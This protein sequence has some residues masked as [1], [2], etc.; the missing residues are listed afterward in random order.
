MSLR[1]SA[2][3]GVLV[4]VAAAATLA[5]PATAAQAADE[6]CGIGRVYVPGY[7]CVI[8]LGTAPTAQS[9]AS[10]S[11]ASAQAYPCQFPITPRVWF[12]PGC[13]FSE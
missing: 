12:P 5:L 10:Q 1:R 2:I 6:K 9:P 3:A 7:G 13:T 4:G 11:P 8:A